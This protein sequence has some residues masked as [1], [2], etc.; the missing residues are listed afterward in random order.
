M[1]HFVRRTSIPVSAAA[2][3]AWHARPG[4]FERL[5]PPWSSATL[6]FFDGIGEGQNAVIR[7]GPGVRW[8]AEHHALPDSADSIEGVLG[9]QDVQ[10]AGPFAEWTHNHRFVP[11]GPHA[12]LPADSMPQHASP[13]RALHMVGNVAEFVRSTYPPDPAAVERFNRLLQPPPDP[14][15]PWFTVRGGSWQMTLADSAPWKPASVPGRY[16]APDIG[17]RCA[18]DPE[19]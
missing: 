7:V 15:E 5:T 13:G 11:D 17:F 14:R 1:T 3:Y 6:A 4:A 19:R 12:L 8:V 9:F 2:L 16:Y 18:K 10:V